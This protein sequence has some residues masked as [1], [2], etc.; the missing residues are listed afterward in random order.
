MRITKELYEE[1]MKTVNSAPPE[2][3]GIFG[4][5]DNINVIV[6]YDEGIKS[7]KMCTYI[8]N[9]E[10]LNNII[11]KWNKEGIVFSGMFHTHYFGVKALSYGDRD[12]IEKIMLSMPKEVNELY[13]PIVVMP[14]KEMVVYKAIKLENKIT[15]QE[16]ELCVEWR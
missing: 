14:Q 4:S 2:S 8:P 15:I 12:Y 9:V 1:I 11:L 7:E 10:L 5:K 3:G 6:F 16:D 13:F